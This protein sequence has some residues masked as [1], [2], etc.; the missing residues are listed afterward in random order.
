MANPPT[1]GLQSGVESGVAY[2][3]INP[4]A[5]F[6]YVNAARAGLTAVDCAITFGRLVER[7]LG[8]VVA[9][10]QCEIRM[11][12]QFA[13]VLASQLQAVVTSFERQFGTI[14]APVTRTAEEMRESLKAASGEKR[15]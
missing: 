9:L 1:P 15:L 4:N 13:K 11:S 8:N 5:Q 14:N 3:E 10:D 2:P 7:S 12:P 6:F